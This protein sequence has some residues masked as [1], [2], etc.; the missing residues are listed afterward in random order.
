MPNL[1]GVP[2]EQ[3]AGTAF[4]AKPRP[5]HIAGAREGH[6][7]LFAL[8]A[9]C[10]SA[11]EA[12]QTFAHYMDMAFGLGRVAAPVGP[13]R[14][15]PSYLKLLQGWGLDANGP[16]GAVLKGYVE[17]RFGIAP[18]FHKAP[19]AHF[20][21]PAWVAYIEE[22]QSSRHQANQVHQ[23]L[24][25]LYEFCQWTLARFALLGPGPQVTL[26]RGS[27]RCEEQIVKGSLRERHAT[28][29]LNNIVS[30]SLDAEQASCF[31]D[32]VMCARVPLAK[33]LYAPGVLNTQ[34]L[35]GEGE[36]LAIGGDYEVHIRY[37]P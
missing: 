36:V 28:L 30:F 32:W 5:L 14:F 33:V 2:A 11:Q 9:R 23:Q 26:W 35:Q 13:R 12:A 1:V 3:L 25:L 31:G 16:A 34:V 4:N 17:S 10:A 27:T 7:G 21:S 6:G 37:E 22:K 29:R 15:R 19:L 20:P 24:D 8:L 18:G